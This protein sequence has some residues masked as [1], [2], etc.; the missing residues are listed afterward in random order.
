MKIKIPIICTTDRH[1]M[2]R[3]KLF[4]GKESFCLSSN[5]QELPKFVMQ[6][7]YC[8]P[9]NPETFHKKNLNV[10]YELTKTYFVAILDS[11]RQVSVYIPCGLD[12]VNLVCRRVGE[13]PELSAELCQRSITRGV[14]N[15]VKVL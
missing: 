13:Y 2:L 1:I 14:S 9:Y 3:K 4:Y 15:G 12:E 6:N 8:I 5:M 11:D 10:F 7:H